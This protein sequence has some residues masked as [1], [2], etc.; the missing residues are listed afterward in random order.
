[1]LT[2]LPTELQ[3]AI[4][5]KLPAHDRVRLY[6]A[7]PK[8]SRTA[9]QR[10][11]TKDKR[12]HAIANGIHKKRIA[13]LSPKMKEFLLTCQPDDPTISPVI[14]AFPNEV[15]WPT[16]DGPTKETEG[17][18][19]VRKIKDGTITVVDLQQVT[20][21][22]IECFELPRLI[23]RVPPSTLD[24]VLRH[25]P[26]L[27][28]IVIKD[29]AV[30]FAMSLVWEGANGLENLKWLEANALDLGLNIQETK[31]ILKSDTMYATFSWSF[32]YETILTFLEYTREELEGLWTR[33]IEHMHVEAAWHIDQKLK[34]YTR[35]EIAIV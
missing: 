15:S 31:R 25:C 30:I 13:R 22:I 7:L 16:T 32:R 33:C 28:D 20:P 29:N 34:A 5:D 4:Y 9:L 12:L 17:Q 6:M 10:N 14:A 18:M 21:E 2:Q 11:V 24:I 19:I 23:A 35:G 8:A 1:M 3:Q 26:A 27:K